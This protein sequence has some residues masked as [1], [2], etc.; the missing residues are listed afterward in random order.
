MDQLK[1]MRAKLRLGQTCF[2][3]DCSRA[4]GK[5]AAHTTFFFF[6]SGLKDIIEV[7]WVHDLLKALEG[8][9]QCNCL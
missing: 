4:P 7:H 6:A 1:E 8:H 5:I 2:P 9:V 3:A